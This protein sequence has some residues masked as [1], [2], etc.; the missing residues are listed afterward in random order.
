V[1][2]KDN[3][4]TACGGVAEAIRRARARAPHPLRIEVEVDGLEQLDQALAAGADIVLLDNFSPAQ[5]RLAVERVAG[6]ALVEISGG[7][8]LDTAAAYAASGASIL[9]VGAL[10]HS[11]RAIDLGLDLC[12]PADPGAS[13]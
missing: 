11:A 10:T 6:R 3:H 5:A 4:V 8:R 7:I 2:I 12:P 13:R 9:S 1:L